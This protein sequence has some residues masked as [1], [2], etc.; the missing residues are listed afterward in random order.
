MEPVLASFKWIPVIKSIQ[1]Y[2]VTSVSCIV[3]TATEKALSSKS[4]VLCGVLIKWPIRQ[5]HR[6]VIIYEHDMTHAVALYSLFCSYWNHHLAWFEV[7]ICYNNMCTCAKFGIVFVCWDRNEWVFI[8][9]V[10]SSQLSLYTCITLKYW[11]IR[12]AN[13][14]LRFFR[15]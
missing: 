13:D 6:N 3:K 12:I 4:C 14:L 8:K 7:Y 9:C 2:A 11:I 10:A 1:I 15:T 5:T